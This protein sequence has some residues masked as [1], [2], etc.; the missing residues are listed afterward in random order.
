MSAELKLKEKTIL[1]TGPLTRWAQ[2][3]AHKTT[4]L[5][6]DVVFVDKNVDMANRFANQLMEAR[7]INDKFGRAAAVASD[8]SSDKSIKDAVSRAAEFFGGLD[9]LVDGLVVPG[10][11]KGFLETTDMQALTNQM[12]ES[13][14]KTL[15]VTQA[16]LPFLTSRKKG[17]V[18]YVVPNAW[19]IVNGYSSIAVARGGLLQLAETLSKEFAEHQTTFN[20]V[21]VGLTEEFLLQATPEATPLKALA[22]LRK[23]QPQAQLSDPDKI[24]DVLVFAVSSLSQGVTGQMLRL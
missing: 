15:S 2:A 20:C 23:T 17:R 5:G 8:L 19:T 13:L 7:E 10:K 12:N 4:Q 14:V 18:V 3:L 24:A 1:V 6:G 11:P 16:M 21:D 9:I 22:E